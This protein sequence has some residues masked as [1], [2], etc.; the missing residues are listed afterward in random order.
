M[1]VD[2]AALKFHCRFSYVQQCYSYKV[3]QFGH[4]KH[5]HTPTRCPTCFFLTI[6][7][8]LLMVLVIGCFPQFSLAN[9]GWMA[10]P[11]PS[12]TINRCQASASASFLAGRGVRIVNGGLIVTDAR[13]TAYSIVL[14]LCG[15]P[16]E[17]FRKMQSWRNAPCKAK[18]GNQ[19]WKKNNASAKTQCWPRLLHFFIFFRNHVCPVMVPGLI[20]MFSPF[21]LHFQIINYCFFQAPFF[22]VVIFAAPRFAF[23]ISFF[24]IFHYLSTFSFFSTCSILES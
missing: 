17:N 22:A 15:F 6:L 13:T 11:W 12:L 3:W 2:V 24:I 9:A 7:S 19:K 21:F 1:L 4:N 23:L 18:N 8:Y 10:S 14:A 20:R 16:L 5:Q